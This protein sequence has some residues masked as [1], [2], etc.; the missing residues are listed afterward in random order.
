MPQSGGNFA[1]FL[2]GGKVP[3]W[4]IAIFC[5]PLRVT[6]VVDQLAPAVDIGMY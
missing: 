6:P 3:N 2:A 4:E 1:V 5:H